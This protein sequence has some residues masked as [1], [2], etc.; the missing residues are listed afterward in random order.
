MCCMLEVYSHIQTTTI[1]KQ[2]QRTPQP[3]H[4]TKKDQARIMN[5]FHKYTWLTE[6]GSIDLLH[7]FSSR[8]APKFPMEKNCIWAKKKKYTKMN[9]TPQNKQIKINDYNSDF[10]SMITKII[11]RSTNG[12][13]LDFNE[14][15]HTHTPLHTHLIEMTHNCITLFSF[16]ALSGG[17]TMN[18]NTICLLLSTW[19]WSKILK[20]VTHQ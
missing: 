18:S 10:F 3:T 14:W 5:K 2:S 4:P 7:Q 6:L 13:F 1:R 17:I 19:S 8:Q 20:V 15:K 9:Y 11:K 12:L 16:N